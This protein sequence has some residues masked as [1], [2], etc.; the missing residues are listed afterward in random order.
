MSPTPG[1][2]PARKDDTLV[3]DHSPPMPVE[4]AAR[5]CGCSISLLNKLRVTGDGPAFVKLG[6]KVSYETADLRAWL[7]S[8]RRTSTSQEAA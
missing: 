8:R 6:R 5:F 2:S 1:F 7:N 3:Q 4:Q